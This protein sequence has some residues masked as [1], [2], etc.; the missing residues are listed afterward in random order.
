MKNRLILLSS[1][2]IVI[3]IGLS[4]VRL[5]G[6]P[7]VTEINPTPSE[8]LVNQSLTITIG[9]END[10]TIT[11]EYPFS[12]NITP[13]SLLEKITMDNQITLETENYDFGVFVKSI[14]GLESGAEMSWIYFVNGE[15][16]Q[17]AA[18]QYKL[19]PGD[20]VEWKYIAPEY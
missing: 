6:N 13:F 14:N 1:A 16:G 18:N 4:F 17:V 7:N 20:M 10:Q 5:Y 8:E 3:I 19:N 11:G 12:E 15:S 2:V 9:Y